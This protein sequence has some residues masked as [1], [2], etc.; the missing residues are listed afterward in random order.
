MGHLLTDL[1]ESKP[2][3]LPHAVRTFVNQ[4]RTL[5]ECNFRHIGDMLAALVATEEAQCGEAAPIVVQDP[6]LASVDQA[7][8]V[9][10][11][12]ASSFHRGAALH[13]AVSSQPVLCAMASQYA[14]FVPM[15]EV[16]LTPKA[17]L[18]LRR[19][20]AAWLDNATHDT[21]QRQARVAAMSAPGLVYSTTEN[22][23]IQNGMA[24]FAAY[25][26][27]SAVVKQLAHSATI[28]RTETKLDEA[29]GL[30]LGR[31]EAEVCA[32]PDEIAAYMLNHQSSRV[33]QAWFAADP[34]TLRCETLETAHACHT[35]VFTRVSLPAMSDRTFLNSSIAKKVSEDPLTYLVINSPI[36]SHCAIG[37]KDEAN[38]V[39]SEAC[40][41][42][43][44]TQVKPGR[45]KIEYC[46]SLDLK[47]RVPQIVTNTIAVPQQLNGA[48]PSP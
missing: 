37:P 38:A 7:A 46:C 2:E 39:R 3:D 26:S 33:G 27:S 44:M 18:E 15:L 21:A 9:G 48:A 42:Y 41:H 43:I 25:E 20:L 35:V 30:L 45:T 24:M 47:G 1:V 8:V 14:W 11:S 16:L 36:P 4:T 32:P 17:T 29:T 40:R 12:L 23:L 6:A 5:R 28:D 34:T 19:E 13:E 10:A 31:A 22:E